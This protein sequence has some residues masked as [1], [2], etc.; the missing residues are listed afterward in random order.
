MQPDYSGSVGIFRI[1]GVVEP[2]PRRDTCKRTS[3]QQDSNFSRILFWNVNKKDLT[4]FVCAIAKSTMADVIVLNENQVASGET[5]QALQQ[6]V[7]G[8]FD[9]PLASESS[10][11]RFHCFC[12]KPTL[13]MSE[14]HSGT[15]T[16]VREFKVGSHRLLLALVHGV[17]MRNNDAETRQD[18]ARS[19]AEEMRFVKKE[20]N[21]NKLVMLG[22]FNMN[23]YDRGMNL[24][25]G[26]NAMMTTECVSRSSRRYDEKEYEFYYNPMWSL[27]GDKTDGPAGTI[28]DTSNQGPY[29]W[30]MLDQV[31]I[32]HSIV[33]L[34][35]DV[36]IMD[37]A[38]EFSLKNARGRPD[39]NK[40]SDH[41]PIL[42]SLRGDV[43]E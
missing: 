4:H 30:S 9:I 2:I 34:F 40:A 42:V 21:T 43:D 11:K 32:H 18:R 28:Y 7:S 19:L 27:F 33:K 20:K 12:R 23:P 38:G 17:D 25:T 31:L 5:L 41:F 13:D 16:S 37:Q 35:H 29:G 39:S 22:D 15:R 14:V 8:D 10:K 6:N 26:L 1:L 36:K 3:M 24:A